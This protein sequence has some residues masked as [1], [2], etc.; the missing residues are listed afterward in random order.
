MSS[1]LTSSAK[2]KRARPMCRAFLFLWGGEIKTHGEVSSTDWQDS[3]SAQPSGC[4][5]GE[6]HGCADCHLT[7]SAA[8]NSQFVSSKFF[9]LVGRALARRHRDS[10]LRSKISGPVVHVIVHPSM[11]V[12]VAA[13]CFPGPPWIHPWRLRR[14]HPCFRRSGKTLPAPVTAMVDASGR[15]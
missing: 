9:V 12:T 1:N 2:N 4:P 8:E 15:W 10:D 5:Q 6:A 14:K 13:R 3:R 7:S 11:S